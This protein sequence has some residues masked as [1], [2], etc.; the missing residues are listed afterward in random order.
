MCV[1][2]I[3][4]YQES[5]EEYWAREVVWAVDTI[6]R[7]GVTLS[8]TRIEKLTN[9]RKKDFIACMPYLQNYEGEYAS[10]IKALM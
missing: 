6:R 7:N 1:Q 2:E 4:K 8:R 10:I 5:Q 3:K 9:M